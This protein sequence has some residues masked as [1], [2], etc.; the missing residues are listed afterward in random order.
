MQ[1]SERK[2]KIFFYIALTLSILWLLFIFSNS[3]DNGIESDQKSSGV[4][5]IIN[6][7]LHAL[8]FKGDVPHIFVRKLAHF[9]E[10]AILAV[11]VCPVIVFA[12]K[13][14]TPL[15]SPPICLVCAMLDELLQNFSVGRGP[16]LS[17]VGID[18]FGAIC[19][20]AAFMALYFLII[21]ITKKKELKEKA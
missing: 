2:R 1:I 11:F 10:F 15:L 12:P 19:G 21:V 16:Q 9:T 13:K 18:T 6:N 8:G 3:L 20:T 4:T 7:V 5:E 14:L 17:D